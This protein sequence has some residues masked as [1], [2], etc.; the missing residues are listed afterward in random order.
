MR[1]SAGGFNPRQSKR[2]KRFSGREYCGF[3]R[4]PNFQQSTGN[5][6]QGK[7]RPLLWYVD[8]QNFRLFALCSNGYYIY[9]SY[10]SAFLHGQTNCA[11]VN[12]VLLK[13]IAGFLIKNM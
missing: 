12:Y 7:I 11:F 4:L 13:H 10:D 8:K 2:P 6:Q 3:I 1:F 5:F 9:V